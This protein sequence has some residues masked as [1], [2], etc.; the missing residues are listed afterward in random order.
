M[1]TLLTFF[2]LLFSSSVFADDIKDYRIEG[3]SIGDNLLDF[4]SEDFVIK[5][6]DENTYDYLDEPNRYYA[7]FIFDYKES[8]NYELD[9][10]DTVTIFYKK[11]NNSY[12]T[13]KNQDDYIIYGIGGKI[14]YEE[15]SNTCI[16]QR[17]NIVN[18]LSKIFND[19]TK[20]EP[21]ISSHIYDKTGNSTVN[22]VSFWFKN[23]DVVMA[24]CYD[25]VK[26]INYFDNLKIQFLTDDLNMWLIGN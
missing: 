15:K 3:F 22:D 17:D 21:Y 24:A 26:P 19:V 6:T 1:K 23:D 16:T 18:E 8:K 7:F 11:Q 5:N 25:W 10:Y 9:K 12:V 4:F 20:T 13:K 2:V 14:I